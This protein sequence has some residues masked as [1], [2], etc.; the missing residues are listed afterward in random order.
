MSRNFLET[1]GKFLEISRNFLEMARKFLGIAPPAEDEEVVGDL[2][3]DFEHEI[4]RRLEHSNDPWTGIITIITAPE[5][6]PQK[7]TEGVKKSLNFC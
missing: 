7:L 5:L 3:D 6:L 4:D 2:V 1:S